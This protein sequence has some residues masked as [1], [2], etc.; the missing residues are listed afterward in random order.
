MGRRDTRWLGSGNLAVR[1]EVFSR[2]NGFDE[3][4]E[5]CEDVDFCQRLRSA[6]WR[7]VADERLL[8]IHLGDPRSLRE[9]FVSERWRGRDN[10]RVS[11]RLRPSLRDYPS[12][13]LPLVGA[14]L[15]I[16]GLLALGIALV[17]GRAAWWMA[18][19]AV[20]A[21][22]ATA[23][24]RALRM[25]FSSRLSRPFD[26]VRA[27]C[28]A[29]AYESGRAASLFWPASHTRRSSSSRMLAADGQA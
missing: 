22:F 24:L 16:F 26:W 5:T 4:L 11:F 7:L 19:I 2:L 1:R 8:N 3:S 12:I 6:G 29:L 20:L 23:G 13:L 21:I 9:L 14:V 28:V 15:T 17:T 25:I 27:Y 10:L 18:A